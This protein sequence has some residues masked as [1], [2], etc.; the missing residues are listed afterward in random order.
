MRQHSLPDRV[1]MVRSCGKHIWYAIL[2]EKKSSKAGIYKSQQECNSFFQLD[3]NKQEFLIIHKI[4]LAIRSFVP[5]ILPVVIKQIRIPLVLLESESA[6]I[7][8]LYASINTID[9]D[10]PWRQSHDRS[11]LAKGRMNGFIFVSV[12]PDPIYPQ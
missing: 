8:L 4:G 6:S 9:S 5:L 3:E 7:H 10:L 2:L 12:I 11:M 1:R